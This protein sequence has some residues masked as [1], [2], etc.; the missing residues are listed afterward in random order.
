MENRKWKKRIFGVSVFLVM[1]MLAVGTMVSFASGEKLDSYSMMITKKLADGA[2]AA[3]QQ[4][5]YQFKIEGTVS[6]KDGSNAEDIK[7]I[8]VTVE[9]KDGS[10]VKLPAGQEKIVKIKGEGSVTLTFPPKMINI[11]AVE[12][13]DAD[14]V[15]EDGGKKWSVT[16]TSCETEMTVSGTETTVRIS[17]PRGTI[18]LTRPSVDGNNNPIPADSLAYYTLTG[19]GFH[20]GKA[21]GGRDLIGPVVPG[22]TIELGNDLDQGVYT[23]KEVQP[24]PG[25]SVLV[26]PREIEVGA[27]GVGKFYINSD[28][29]TLTI[30]APA[31]VEGESPR[32]HYYR[33]ESTDG[34]IKRD[35][36][37]RTDETAKVEHLPKG[38]YTIRV[39]KTYE[40]S[41]GNYVVSYPKTVSSNYSMKVTAV[42]PASGTIGGFGYTEI[43]RTYSYIGNLTYGPLYD[44]NDKVVD[45]SVKYRFAYGG[46]NPET[47]KITAWTTTNAV[48]GNKSGNGV[49]LDADE[50]V[51]VRNPVDNRIRGRAVYV[52]DPVAKKLR[53]SWTEYTELEDDASYTCQKT[54]TEYY[55]T[56]DRR[57]YIIVSKPEDPNDKGQQVS[58]TYTIRDSAG[59]EKEVVLCAGESQKVEG[60]AAGK[61]YI[62]ETISEKPEPLPFTVELVETEQVLTNAGESTSIT[63]LGDR[64]VEISKPAGE[65]DGRDYSFKIEGTDKDGTAHSGTITLKAGEQT[66]VRDQFET[67]PEGTYTITAEN[68][69]SGLSY[70]YTVKFNDGSTLDLV[71][72]KQAHVTFTNTF[73]EKKNS[74]RVV[75]E[76]YD[77][78]YNH[79]GSTAIET[80]NA[81]EGHGDYY[82]ADEITKLFDFQG[83]RYKHVGEAYGKVVASKDNEPSVDDVEIND[84]N[85]EIWSETSRY[86]TGDKGV[87]PK[88]EWKFAYKPLENMTDGVEATED[89]TQIIIIRYIQ[90]ETPVVKAGSYKVV[91]EYYHRTSAG[92]KLEGKRE[93]E[94]VSVK[95]PSADRLYTA[96]DHAK[97]PEFQPKDA[98]G[99]YLY[100][101]DENPAYGRMDESGYKA[102]DA[103]TG[104]KATEAGDQIII[105]RYY[106]EGTPGWYNVV[107]EYY[108]REPVKAGEDSGET[109]HIPDEEGTNPDAGGEQGLNL[110]DLDDDEEA[111]EEVSG[112]HGTLSSDSQYTYTF[113]GRRDVVAKIPATGGTR[114]TA[115]D[116]QHQLGFSGNNYQ[117][118]SAVYGRLNTS[119]DEAP[120]VF[121]EGK[122]DAVATEKGDEIIILRYI[123]GDDP[124]PPSPGPG[125][126][127]DPGPGPG[128]G[129]DPGPNPT[130]PPDNPPDEPPEEPKEP[131]EPPVEPENPPVEPEEPPVDP[132]VDP[133]E[134]PGYP[135]ELPD[136]NDPDSPDEI[137]IWEDGVPKTY[138][139][140]WDPENE[141]YVYLQE[142]DIPLSWLDATPKTGD[143]SMTTLWAALAAL[144]LGGLVLLRF[145]PES[146]N[147][148]KS[149]RKQ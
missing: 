132:P 108:Y 116:V 89:G 26:G 4:Q 18:T 96:N 43:K 66:F 135:T 134:N 144:S 84:G 39:Y 15:I 59:N 13:I 125:T 87:G 79:V 22:A 81:I 24:I 2:P 95:D 78:N 1:V 5:E 27:G 7:N 57:G 92:D 33:I 25:F 128:P 38:E 129:P 124:Q 37:V 102:D 130:P 131:E 115:S 68:D 67:L 71:T 77:A 101:Y 48:A 46:M 10:E 62:T 31:L 106:R 11:T 148:K 120:Y 65:D 75:H 137:T 9:Y 103:M 30:K 105:L 85:G 12:E 73:G 58:Y 20:G 44:A 52:T 126:D 61:V 17:K 97:L 140:V 19:E 36:E 32:T 100:T 94:T 51:I 34:W 29:S 145:M 118:N 14:D 142:E 69:S 104:V 112:F 70:G 53:I 141:E 147:A 41:P 138:F 82:T 91:H 40:G 119:G 8:A 114:F 139:K 42:Y 113:E 110:A 35:I 47:G 56:I 74:Y 54:G 123:R 76:Y 93:I 16:E 49:N 28:K 111:D 50:K 88:G 21:S 72:D 143:N 23:I 86:L 83:Q 55:V 149:S 45:A 99:P 3:A 98:E 64:T 121:I 90:E 63:I 109:E 122:A 6:D 146:K 60:L 133:P 80:M 136:P 107:H 127:P 117:Y